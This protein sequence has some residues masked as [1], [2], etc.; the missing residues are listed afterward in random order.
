[1]RVLVT[2]GAGFIGS[3]L[4]DRLLSEGHAGRVLDNLEPRVH[5]TRGP[6]HVPADVEFLRGDMRNKEDWVQSLQGVE[7]VFHQA[8]HQDHMPEYSKFF[9]TNAS[10][11]AKLFEVVREHRYDV[12]KIVV[13]SSQAVYGEGQYRCATHGPFQAVPR[14]YA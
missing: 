9:E 2:G 10:G 13:A 3:H 12:G 8:A 14:P 4:V 1:M 11:T 6:E 7:V 5:R